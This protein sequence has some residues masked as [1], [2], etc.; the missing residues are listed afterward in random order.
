MS[1]HLYTKIWANMRTCYCN[2]VTSDPPGPAAVAGP[3]AGTGPGVQSGAGPRTELGAG[4]G[5][6]MSME[7]GA[8]PGLDGAGGEHGAGAGRKAGDEHGAEAVRPLEM[9]RKSRLDH[10]KR[11]FGYISSPGSTARPHLGPRRNGDGRISGPVQRRRLHL[12]SKRK[13][14]RRTS[15][16]GRT[17]RSVL[18]SAAIEDYSSL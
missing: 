15:R 1:I 10:Q 3:W 5:P 8:G 12:R 9:Q 6:G 18:Q 13:R 2:G 17:N 16:R 14:P 4:A 7:P 11:D